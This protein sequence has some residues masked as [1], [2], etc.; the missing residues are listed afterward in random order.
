MRAF[1][2]SDSKRRAQDSLPQRYISHMSRTRSRP[3]EMMAVAESLSDEDGQDPRRYHD[4][5]TW[6][7]PKKAGRKARQLCEQVADA[8]RTI[9]AGLADET[10][11]NLTVMTVAPAPHTGRLLVTVAGPAPADAT[12]RPAVADVLAALS[13]AAGRIRSEVAACIHRRYAP[14]LTFAAI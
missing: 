3:L 2:F 4:R 10:L 13:K 1:L 8:L 9:L 12:D 7:E 14:E 6:D 11:Q 5:R